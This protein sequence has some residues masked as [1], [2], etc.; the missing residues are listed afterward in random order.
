MNEAIF[1]PEA[2]TEVREST[3]FYDTHLDGLGL[4][5]LE[6]VERTVDRISSN[7]NA[8]AP[9]A[10]GFRRSIVSGFPFSIIYRPWEDSV[11]LVAVAHHRRR[12]GYW[13]NRVL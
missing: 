6:A 13:Q 9:L 2:R 12:P 1:H 8:G 10:D 3:E 7:P 4:R 5:F 11:Y